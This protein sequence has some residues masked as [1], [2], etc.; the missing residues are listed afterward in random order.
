MRARPK[1]YTGE[2]PGRIARGGH[3]PKA[4]NIPFS[5]LVEESNQTSSKNGRNPA[6][7]LQRRPA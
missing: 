1:F 4:K 6:P 2:D 3:I 7:T 5:T